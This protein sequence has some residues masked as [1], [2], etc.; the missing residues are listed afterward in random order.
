MEMDMLVDVL[1][2]VLNGLGACW[3]VEVSWRTA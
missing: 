2:L 3:M 1:V